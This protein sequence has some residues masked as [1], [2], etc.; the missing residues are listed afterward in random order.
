MSKHSVELQ[1][2][3]CDICYRNRP[4]TELPEDWAYLRFHIG[5]FPE[6]HIC[7]ECLRFIRR[8][9]KKLSCIDIVKAVWAQQVVVTMT[10]WVEDD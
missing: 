6:H 1:S 3:T 2:Y 7:A 5:T 9:H 4:G 10:H 8:L